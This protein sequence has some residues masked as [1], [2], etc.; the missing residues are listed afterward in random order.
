[1]V[2]YY[3]GVHILT[4]FL[5]YATIYIGVSNHTKRGILL[6]QSILYYLAENAP[7]IG[8][9]VGSA[10]IAYR[11]AVK[12]AEELCSFPKC[13]LDIKKTYEQNRKVLKHDEYSDVG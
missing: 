1:M 11:K 8:T 6:Q 10:Y 7:V 9:A 5:R 4:F 13:N 3:T 2:F 12:R